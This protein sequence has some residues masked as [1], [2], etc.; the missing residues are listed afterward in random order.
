[1]K[2]KRGQTPVEEY[3]SHFLHTYT[4][5]KMPF[6]GVLNGMPSRRHGD[7]AQKTWKASRIFEQACRQ[8]FIRKELKPLAE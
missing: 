3:K 5:E 1:M 4:A 8:P 7:A 2:T 6:H